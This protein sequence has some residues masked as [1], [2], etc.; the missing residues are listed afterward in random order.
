MVDSVREVSDS[1]RDDRK[2]PRECMVELCDKGCMEGGIGS[3]G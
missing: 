3:L 1:V 2:E